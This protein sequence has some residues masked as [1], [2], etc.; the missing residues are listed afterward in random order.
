MKVYSKNNAVFDFCESWVHSYANHANHHVNHHESSHGIHIWKEE[1]L[2]YHTV[3]DFWGFMR[4]YM[5]CTAINKFA[6]TLWELLRITRIAWELPRIR[7]ESVENHENCSRITKKCL[8][9]GLESQASLKDH[10]NHL[11]IAKIAQ[12]SLKITSESWD[13]LE[14]RKKLLRITQ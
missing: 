1:E 4:I 7:Q 12:E 9:I 2:L 13:L 11:R 14:N 3:Q 5:N 8:I 10:E 6:K